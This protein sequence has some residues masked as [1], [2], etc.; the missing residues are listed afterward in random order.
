MPAKYRR[1]R[2][3][4]AQLLPHDTGFTEDVIVVFQLGPA[5]G[6]GEFAGESCNVSTD[7]G[8]HGQPREVFLD[9]ATID[10]STQGSRLLVEHADHRGIPVTEDGLR[11]RG[12]VQVSDQWRLP[13]R[14]TI[15][16]QPLPLRL[17]AVG[18]SK[19]VVAV[20]EK[21]H[22]RACRLTHAGIF[23]LELAAVTDEGCPNR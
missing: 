20:A 14:L 15:L 13:R 10:I 21:P 18:T 9:R 2:D 22:P 23:L 12:R 3:C 11:L 16:M 19:D 1:I 4:E 8:P 7:P 5:V 6:A 17:H